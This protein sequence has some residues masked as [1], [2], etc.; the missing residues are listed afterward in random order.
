MDHSHH[1]PK[2]FIQWR[3]SNDFPSVSF[4]SSETSCISP[5]TCQ[6]SPRL[7]PQ[8]SFLVYIDSLFLK[9]KSLLIS[10]LLIFIC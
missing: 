6:S 2:H 10:G 9:I 3:G 4:V 7:G 8:G 5:P 1:L